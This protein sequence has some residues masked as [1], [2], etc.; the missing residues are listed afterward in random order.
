LTTDFQTAGD[1]HGSTIDVL[2]SAMIMEGR[3]ENR[4]VIPASHIK[5]VLRQEAVRLGIEERMVELMFGR[6]EQEN[7]KEGYKEPAVKFFD[8]YAP[9]RILNERVHVKISLKY[10]SNSSNDGGSIQR[11]SYPRELLSLATLLLK[12]V[13]Q[14]TLIKF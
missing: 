1:T 2:K 9:M 11:S 7:G 6:E 10:G 4:L 5:G 3:V 13:F 12:E 8:L 14:R